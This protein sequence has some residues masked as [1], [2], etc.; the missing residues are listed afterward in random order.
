MKST[1]VDA[2]RSRFGFWYLVVSPL[3]DKYTYLITIDTVT[4][5][6][7]YSGIPD[8]DIFENH[9]A[10][11]EHLR[12]EDAEIKVHGE[13][14]V[15]LMTSNNSSTIAIIDET[16]I[17]GSL[18]NIHL[19]KTIKHTTFIYIPL[20]GS[21]LTT[22]PYEEFQINN[23]HYFCD[24]YDLTNLYPNENKSNPMPVNTGFLWNNGWRKPFEILGI[25]QV[26]IH[27]L[28]GACIT[29][30]F[31]DFNFSLTYIARRSSLNPGT[32]FVARGLNDVN[33]PG[34]ALE[35]E[36]IF[37][38][39][40][41]FWTTRWIRGSIPIR[42]KT[43]MQ[44][45]VSA[46]KNYVD[47]DYFK[48]TT[49][50]FQQL[51]N[52]FEIIPTENEQSM[53]NSGQEP[54]PIPIRCFSLL[55][56][57]G[58]STEKDVEEFYEKAI[59]Q[60]NEEGFQHVSIIHYDLAKKLKSDGSHNTLQ[61]FLSIL[62]PISKNDGFTKG[63][64]ISQLD[65]D[66]D[67]PISYEI[68][69]TDHQK[70]VFR[71]NCIDSLDRTN[72]ATFYYAMNVTAQ[73]C[74]MMKTGLCEKLRSEANENY[75]LTRPDFIL[76]QTIIDFLAISFVDVGNIISML[77]TNTK[78]IKLNAIRTFAPH[79]I[80]ATNDA[81]ISIQRRFANAN[82]DP[83][84][85]K[86]IE[87]W[88]A[89]ST[90]SFYHRI[91]PNH[92]FIVPSNYEN[93]IDDPIAQ[94]FPFSRGIISNDI[95][96][97]QL[98]EKK[99]IV[100][101]SC[102]MIPFALILLM[103]PSNQ[104]LQ[105][106][107]V[108]GGMNLDTMNLISEI[109]LPTVE[110]PMWCRYKLN[111]YER[112]ALPKRYQGYVRFISLEFYVNSEQYTIGAI[113]FETKSIFSGEKIPS[114]EFN[115]PSSV[116]QNVS[117]EDR[118]NY[119]AQNFASYVKSHMNLSDTIILEKVRL[120]CAVSEE[121]RQK[122]AIEN[123]INPWYVDAK[124]QI[125]ASS[126]YICAFC[127]CP[128]MN[129]T[130]AIYYQSRYYQ[131]LITKNPDHKTNRDGIP[132]CHHCIEMADRI[133]T[134]ADQYTLEYKSP[135]YSIPHF[136]I[137]RNQTF[138]KYQGKL[139]AYT[140]ETT[141]IFLNNECSLLWPEN[142]SIILQK[143]ETK[144]LDLFL[145]QVSFIIKIRIYANSTNLTI[146]DD[147]NGQQLIGIPDSSLFEFTYPNQPI[148]QRLQLSIHANEEVEINR[149][150]A[151]YVTMPFPPEKSALKQPEA[152][153]LPQSVEL[154]IEYNSLQHT[155][156]VTLSQVYKIYYVQ[157]TLLVEPGLPTPLSLCVAFYLDNKYVESKM[158]LLPQSPNESKMWYKISDQGIQANSIK[159]FYL[160]R[161][162]SCKSLLYQ[163]S[164]H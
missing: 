28:Q 52:R 105:K 2:L 113:K 151:Y 76:D 53:F 90:V 129:E 20:R 34:N 18:P 35:C 1:Q 67:K 25:P 123:G 138:P 114:N 54:V 145:L 29:Q 111:D 156:M 157:V 110:A 12:N 121:Y 88:V 77:Y 95:K 149:I 91:D 78:A 97:F 137:N 27:M 162:A 125:E 164:I 161:V 146:T 74:L 93:I 37:T 124:S 62:I 45:T 98:T 107:T 31:H 119:F 33:A 21:G 122:L 132:I 11:M 44:T 153:V 16:S 38:R 82:D 65:E 30:T 15:G 87:S 81:S 61:E 148:T 140:N 63:K 139:E 3:N 130:P 51:T 160:D 142:G 94:P 58:K 50:Y 32:R 118:N 106:V 73:W 8:I 120:S 14:L 101:F 55:K 152:L 85:Q 102:P 143:G 41:E 104:S 9:E 68:V 23:N 4:G 163:F 108:R 147:E 5:N 79:F 46:I 39:G 43:S 59:S 24:T 70:G 60:L 48:G 75:D 69:V 126:T 26:C 13:G 57:H 159:I 136:T 86:L 96:Q 64:F 7:F 141:A 72:L 128:F 100:C 131:G 150:I 56:K 154:P 158:I 19:V 80:D 84:K 103:S 10:A 99:L 36:L 144:H 71:F 135:S 133:A 115:P 17:T 22:S 109:Q 112:S 117:I 47:D 40:N 42:W 83:E 155:E 49:D 89:P 66:S 116:S 92:V 134:I 6:P 127:K